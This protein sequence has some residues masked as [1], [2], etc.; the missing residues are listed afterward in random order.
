[1]EPPQLC[2]AAGADGLEQRHGIFA[3]QDKNSRGR[4][5]QNLEQ[6]IL[7]FRCQQ[8]GPIEDKDLKGALA[9]ADEALTAQLADVFDLV[10]FVGR[11]IIKQDV[12][13]GTGSSLQ[14][15]RTAATGL[16]FPGAV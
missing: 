13:M 10:V 8:V 9:G 5:F 3:C 1:M 12:G 7:R 16:V 2:A 4:L 14:T 11:D 15:G 6:S